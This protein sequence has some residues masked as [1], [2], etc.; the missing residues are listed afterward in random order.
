MGTEVIC[1]GEG[2]KGWVEQSV[3]GAKVPEGL[4]FDVNP[5]FLACVLGHSTSAQVAEGKL[6][7]RSGT[8]THIMALPE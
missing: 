5:V 6:I 3:S 8:F 7:F 1:K 4:T 2:G